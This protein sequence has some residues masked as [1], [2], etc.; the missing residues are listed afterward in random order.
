MK[1][2]A[3]IGAGAWGKNLVRTFYELK[4]LGVICDV[5]PQLLS[6]Y[7]KQYPDV[8]TS[9]HDKDVLKDKSIDAVVI[10][11]PAALHFTLA[12]EAILAGKDVFVEKPLALHVKEGEELVTLA[13]RYKKILMVGHILHYHNAILKLKALIDS[14]ELGDIRYVYSNRLNI[15]KIRSEENILWSFAPHDISVILMLLGEK[16]VSLSTTGESYLQKGIVDLTMT[17]M[18]FANGVKAHIFVSWLHPFKEQKLIV[19]GSKK[20]AVFD[21]VS[22][23]K[24]FLYP[25]TVTWVDKIPVAERAEAEVVD[26]D[27]EEPL[28]CECRHFLECLVSRKQPRTD[29]REGLNV[30]E[31]LN[32]SEESLKRGRA[33][34][35]KTEKKDHLQK[36]FVH[37]SS[38]IDEQVT[39]GEGTQIWHY[40]HVLKNST[41]GKNCKIGQNVMIGPDAEIGNNCK[42]QNNVSV[43]QG[44][45]LEE[46][47]F[48]GPSMVFTNVMNPRSEIPRM[49]ELKK[50]LVKKGATIGANATILCGITIGRS[51]FIGAGAVVT[52]D[53]SDYALIYGN[54]GALKGWMCECGVKLKVKGAKKITCESCGKHF[55]LKKKKLESLASNH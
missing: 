6:S 37:E 26:F 22:A 34:A 53:V 33:I 28:L 16:P 55:I 24:L 30:L 49:S 12:R 15:G 29:G 43:Y 11:A 23:Q 13:D 51:A 32:D 27:R 35:L 52:K 7:Q 42:I 2:L 17:T 47:V 25:H 38:C 50:T 3:V 5:N 45:T 19:V 36:Y 9:T 21:D 46:G 8:K 54:P 41:I 31:I 40:S 4:S 20:M 10:A 18:N 48:C 44:V 14:G 39:I 1:K